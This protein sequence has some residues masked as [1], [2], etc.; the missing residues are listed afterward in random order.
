MN[1]SPL[2]AATSLSAGLPNHRRQVV[3]F[4]TVMSNDMYRAGCAF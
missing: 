3:N 1:L 2:H 4:H